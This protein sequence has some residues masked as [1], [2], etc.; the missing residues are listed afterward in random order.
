MRDCH[1]HFNMIKYRKLQF[2]STH[3]IVIIHVSN[4]SQGTLKKKLQY[5][6]L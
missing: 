1:I 4:G 5:F 6:L 2:T 3:A